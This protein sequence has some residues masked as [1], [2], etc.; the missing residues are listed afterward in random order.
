MMAIVFLVNRPENHI[1]AVTISFDLAHFE[2]G[3]INV[4]RVVQSS[5]DQDIP[6]FTGR[7]QPP[8]GNRFL[9]G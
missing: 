7:S 3:T 9:S 2:Q 8:A 4:L 6:V 1:D 5:D